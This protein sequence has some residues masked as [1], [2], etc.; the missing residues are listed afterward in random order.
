MIKLSIF[1]P[2]LIKVAF[3][4]KVAQSMVVLAPMLTLSSSSTFPSCG[5]AI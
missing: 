3:S 1:A 2:F 5:M 4:G